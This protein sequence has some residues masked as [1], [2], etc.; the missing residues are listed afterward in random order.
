MTKTDFIPKKE[1]VIIDAHW[2]EKDE[3]P[4]SVFNPLTTDFV[5]EVREDNNRVR[6]YIIRSM[7][8]ET[9]PTY[10]A[11]N[12]IKRLITAVQNKR[13]INVITDTDS[14]ERIRKEIEIDKL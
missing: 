9:F 2:I 4:M 14:T 1:V 11:K 8:I 3:T 13:G 5:C 12:I 7:E 6:Q 10:L